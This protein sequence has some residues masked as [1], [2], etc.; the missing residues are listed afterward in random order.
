M[1][2]RV[3]QFAGRLKSC[4]HADAVNQNSC[5]AQSLPVDKKTSRRFKKL[6]KKVT[7]MPQ[8]LDSQ[9]P[10]EPVFE[11]ETDLHP[12]LLKANPKRAVTAAVISN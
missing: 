9:L 4:H 10:L 1:T 3:I 8:R 5:N 7:V 6:V 2:K 11:A 12:D